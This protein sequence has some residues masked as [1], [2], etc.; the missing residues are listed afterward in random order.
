M[1]AE[2]GIVWER[3]RN[4]IFERFPTVI[5]HYLLCP[6]KPARPRLPP[7][8]LRHGISSPSSLAATAAE[9][10]PVPVWSRADRRSEAA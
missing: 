7:C 8:R 6:V 2:L 5:K 10:D 4:L 3:P 1:C 9:A